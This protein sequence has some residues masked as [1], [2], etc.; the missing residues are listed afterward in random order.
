MTASNISFIIVVLVIINIV[1]FIKMYVNR[2]KFDTTEHIY[3][4]VGGTGSG[5]TLTM[6]TEGVKLW[7][8]F[9]KNKGL[10]ITNYP[11]KIGKNKYSCKLEDYIF[12]IE[13]K[14]P[15]NSVI[16]IDEVGAWFSRYGFKGLE[17]ESLFLRLSRQFANCYILMADQRI[18]N[19]PINF[20]DKINIVYSL[21]EFRKYFFGA[22]GGSDV[23]KINY[24]V[25]LFQTVNPEEKRSFFRIKKLYKSRMYQ[26]AYNEILDPLDPK[27]YDDLDISSEVLK[28]MISDIYKQMNKKTNRKENKGSKNEKELESV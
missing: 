28:K 6:T 27:Y 22:Y 11:V 24:N 14:I 21:T 16:L 17:L 10:L 20:R 7:K 23:K 13:K 5:K 12:K 15:D 1:K 19:I 8:S 3:A 4:F 2:E 25:D 26:K 18:G 9:K